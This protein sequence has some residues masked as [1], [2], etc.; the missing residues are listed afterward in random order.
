MDIEKPSNSQSQE[1]LGEEWE[2][3]VQEIRCFAKRKCKYCIVTA[4]WNEGEKSYEQYRR[5]RPYTKE[6]DFIVANRGDDLP[7]LGDDVL[8]NEFQ[9]R[10]LL[11]IEEPGQSAAYRAALAYGL[12]EGYDGIIMIDS[13]GKDGVEKMPSFV[14]HLDEGFDL[15]NGSRFMKGGYHENTPLYRVIAIRIIA[16][17]ILWLGSHYWYTDQNNGFKA[18][19]REFLLD[20]RVQPFRKIFQ[21]HNLQVYLNYAAAKHKFL[22][23]QVPTSRVYPSEGPIPSKFVSIRQFWKHLWDYIDAARGRYNP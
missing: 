12:R 19:S 20:D 21:M 2:L 16:A 9:I 11:Q 6:L 10:T 5:M 7:D 14:S 4:C 22:V 13:N 23:V 15:V 18:F 17:G 3:P 8:K 1:P